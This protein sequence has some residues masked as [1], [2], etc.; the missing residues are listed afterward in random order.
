MGVKEHHEKAR[1]SVTCAVIT[2]SDT[3]TEATDSSGQRI[4]EMLA[5]GGHRVKSCQIVRD[6]PSEIEAALRRLLE[7]RSVE[8]I[9]TNGGTGISPRD[10]TFEVIRA[11]LEREIDGFGELFRVLSYQDIGPAAM[12]SRALAGTAR[13]K[14]VVSLPGSTAAVE[15]GMAKLVLP[16]LGHMVFLLGG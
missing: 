14:V 13:G 4:R 7:D 3:R 1:R 8:A 2:V 6:E 5:D 16:E 9:I 10:T 12:L 11:L 15:L